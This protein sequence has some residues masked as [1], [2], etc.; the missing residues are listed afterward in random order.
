MLRQLEEIRNL[1]GKRILLRLDLN[2]PLDGAKVSAQGSWRLVRSLPTI[3]YLLKRKA[4]II[5]VAHLGR[6]EGKRDS[7]YSLLPVC[8]ALSKLVEKP[9]EFWANDFRNYYEDSAHLAEGQLVM[10]ENIRFEP[11]EKKNSRKLAGELSELADVYVN[12]AFG[13][14]HRQDASME[15]ITHYLPAYSGFLLREEISNLSQVLEAGSGLSVIFG[16]AKIAD[17]I[18][19]IKK[20]SGSGTVLVGG[21]LANTLLAAAGY[22]MGKSLVDKSSLN[23]AK[24]LLKDSVKL[25]LDVKVA[26]SFKAKKYRSV[27]VSRLKHKDIALDIGSQ[28]IKEYQK[29]LRG[30]KLIVWNG[31]L[32]YFENKKFVDGSRQIAKYLSKLKARVIVGGGETVELI[33]ELGLTDKFYFV[34]TGG[35]AMLTF[36][37]GGSM[38]ALERLKRN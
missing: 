24:K 6:P 32:G 15:A 37:E 11:G 19:L 18:K 13:N 2:V 3:R 22:R 1:E 38:P 34:S 7:Q 20:F 21:A 8:Q 9:I 35:G 5:I 10:L 23:T 27:D 12:D 25:P 36:L 14:L 33:E 26:G 28:T 16:G 4:S 29:Y 31:P 17:K 30:A